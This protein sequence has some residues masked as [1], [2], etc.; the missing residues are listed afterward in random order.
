MSDKEYEWHHCDKMLNYFS[1]TLLKY[2]DGK[3][4]EV[5]NGTVKEITQCQW[6]GVQ[7]K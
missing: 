5:G 6:C 4:Y 2:D 7:L 1:G 3:W